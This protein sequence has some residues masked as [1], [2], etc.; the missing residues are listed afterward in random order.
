[1]GEGDQRA[2]SRSGG[3]GCRI[4][5][6]AGQAVHGVVGVTGGVGDGA[7]AGRRRGGDR[8]AGVADA[9]RAVVKIV[10]VADDGAGRR[11][12]AGPAVQGV[13]GE[14]DGAPGTG[15]ARQRVVERVPGEGLGGT[16][17]VGDGGQPVDAV[18]R[19]AGRVAVGV[20]AAR[21]LAVGGIGQLQQ[22]PR[23][24]GGIEGLVGVA[25]RIVGELRDPSHGVGDGALPVEQVVGIA[26]D[27]AVGVGRRGDLAA[28][29]IGRARGAQDGA[30]GGLLRL[31]KP[32]VGIVGIGGDQA[33]RGRARWR[34]GLGDLAAVGVVGAGGDV[35]LGIGGGDDVAAG[36]VGGSG[37]LVEMAGAG[38]GDRGEAVA[39]A[40]IGIGGDHAHRIGRRADEAQRIVRIS[41]PGVEMRRGARVHRD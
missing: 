27:V 22:R 13:V 10:G 30:V 35:A 38:V 5:G 12:L 33:G 6:G 16:Q 20:L 36:V 41:G 14:G 21:D 4:P 19:E 31:E 23:L 1:M 15:L 24:D 17:R 28:G 7:A 18:V 26:R 3:G 32:A 11:R 9:G 2:C 37:R 40:V 8:G 29:R 34:C 25:Q 39:Q